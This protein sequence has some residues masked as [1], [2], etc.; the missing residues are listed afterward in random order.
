MAIINNGTQNLLPNNQIPSGYTR[1]TIT[2]FSLTDNHYKQIRSLTVLKS[3][4]EN[5]TKSTT[6]TNIFDDVAIGLD[7]QVA[8]IVNNDFDATNTVESFAQLRAAGSNV[9]PTDTGSDWLNDTATSFTCTV[10]I[11]VK[12]T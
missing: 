10:D 11:F 6:M 3:T 1:P 4:V 8:D 5:A 12:V 7:K 2:T 9:S